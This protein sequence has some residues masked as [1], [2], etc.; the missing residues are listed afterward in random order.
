MI[1]SHK[2]NVFKIM[3]K[4]EY[5]AIKLL[6]SITC[7]S[8]TNLKKKNYFL[9]NIFLNIFKINSFFFPNLPT[10]GAKSWHNYQIERWQILLQNTIFHLINSFID[11]LC[12]VHRYIIFLFLPL[13]QQLA[14]L[15]MK[16]KLTFVRRLTDLLA[17]EIYLSPRRNL[18]RFLYVDTLRV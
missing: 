4:I 9:S 18:S 8:S 17:S 7:N 16:R 6:H 3:M 1:I 10:A 13:L 2:W 14:S 11:N 12:L 15:E 5:P